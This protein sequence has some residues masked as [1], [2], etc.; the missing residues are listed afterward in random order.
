[1]MSRLNAIEP[2]G[3][4]AM[5]DSLLAGTGLV[6]KLNQALMQLGEAEHWNF[7]HIIITDGQ[8]TSSKASL[9]DTAAAM[10]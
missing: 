1:M 8:D 2:S 7:V 5:R 3:G 4:T 9:E 6:L 10:L